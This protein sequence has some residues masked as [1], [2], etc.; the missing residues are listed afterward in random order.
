[1]TPLPA[2]PGGP[3]ILLG[4]FAEAG[5]RRARRIGNGWIAPEL[6]H[7]GG[8][9]KRIRMLELES[10]S[11]PFHVAVTLSAFVAARDA[12]E[13]VRPGAARVAAQYRSWLTESGDLTPPDRA[14]APGGKPPQFVAGTPEECAEQLRPWWEALSALPPCVVPHFALRTTFPGVSREATLESV[15]LL[16][17][18]VVPRLRATD[19]G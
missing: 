2:R 15:R 7:P 8:L 4:A 13:T 6:A 3:P 16:A 18:D 10:R 17:R 11:E 12:W 1:V 9:A 19:R 14:E 5:V